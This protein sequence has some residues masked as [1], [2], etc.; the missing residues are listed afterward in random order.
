M[1][2]YVIEIVIEEGSDEFWEEITADGKTGCDEVLQTIKD[3]IQNYFP[4]SV[5]L[6][7]FEDR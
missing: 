3:E 1:K 6:I 2:R 7:K 4:E 5:R